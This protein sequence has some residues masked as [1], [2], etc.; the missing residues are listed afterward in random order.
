MM[1]SMLGALTG[2]LILARTIS[3]KYDYGSSYVLQAMLAS[4]F[5]GLSPLFVRSST[6]GILL[7]I[8]ILLDYLAVKY[9]QKKEIAR[10]NQAAAR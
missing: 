5:A 3:A 1:S 4:V 7:I 9:R 2:I 10:A 8:G 6:Y